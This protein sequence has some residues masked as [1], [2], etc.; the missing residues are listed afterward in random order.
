[1]TDLLGSRLDRANIELGKELLSVKFALDTYRIIGLNAS[2]I[3]Q[4]HAFF[5]HVQRLNHL[6]VALG[7]A[8][9]YEREKGHELCSVS[10]VYRLAKAAQIKNPSAAATFARA[11]GVE[12][13]GEWK[14]DVAEVFAK[15]RPIVGKHLKVVDAVRNTRIA[16]LQQ[17]PLTGDLP[18]IAAFEELLALAVAFHGFVNDG[19][20]DTSSHPIL[21]DGTMLA[22]LATV[23]ESIGVSNVVHDFDDM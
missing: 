20:L 12:P 2:R 19:F 14:E 13:S 21:T 22:S 16:H 8:K 1:M 23:L 7:L 5:G 6:Y 11:Y 10:G 3:D 18:S 4:A 9:I 17:D 15:H